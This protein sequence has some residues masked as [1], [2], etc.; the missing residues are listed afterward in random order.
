[1]GF[2]VNATF[3]GR[4]QLKGENNSPT[5]DYVSAA[6]VLTVGQLQT[7][8]PFEHRTY[9]PNASSLASRT[10][11]NG[12]PIKWKIKDVEEQY[13]HGIRFKLV[14]HDGRGGDNWVT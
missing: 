9:T 6:E 11:A 3:D 14:R 7:Q 2:V 13:E 4:L 8:K 1:M 10:S 5:P 12:T